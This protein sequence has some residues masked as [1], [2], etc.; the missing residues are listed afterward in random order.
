MKGEII[1]LYVD[2]TNSYEV[3]YAIIG[4][5]NQTRRVELLNTDK[6]KRKRE[7]RSLCGPGET[8]LDFEVE[9]IPIRN[10]SG[11]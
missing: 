7:A 8:I 9:G 11:S 4:K 3:W 1:G 6:R 10:M 5:G 2:D